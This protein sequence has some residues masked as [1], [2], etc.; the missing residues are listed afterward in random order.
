MRFQEIANPAAFHGQPR[1]AWGFYGHRLALYRQTRPGAAFDMLREIARHLPHGAFVFTSN[2]DGQF[3]KAGFDPDRI[4]ECHGSI[5]HLQCLEPCS[6]TIW[7]A[8]GFTPEIDAEACELLNALPLCPRCGALARPNILMFNDWGWI[9]GRTE[10]QQARLDAWRRKL[11]CPVVIEIGAGTAIP[12]VRLFGERQSAPLIRINLREAGP[13]SGTKVCLPLKASEAM[14]G[15]VNA[16][17]REGFP[18]A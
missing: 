8:E 18:C 13:S 4:L 1:L 14:N 15:I 17:C 6:S 11:K 7:P 2:V 10:A 5:H 12:S 16:L 3:Q 9:E